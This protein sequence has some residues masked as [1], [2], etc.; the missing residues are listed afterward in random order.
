MA[1]RF[2]VRPEGLFDLASGAAVELDVLPPARPAAHRAW[3]ERMTTLA[4]LWHPHLL[5]PLDFGLLPNGHRFAARPA[6]APASCGRGACAAVLASAARFLG[7]QGLTAG[8]ADARRVR[9]AD[10]HL[11]VVVDERTGLPLADG[12]ARG[13]GG[14]ASRRGRVAPRR[15]LPTAGVRLQPRVAFARIV[16]VLDTVTPG[17]P[18]SIRV[19][20]AKGSGLSTLLAIVAAEARRRGLV[21]VDA[22]VAGRWP[23]LLP[24]LDGRHVLVID[25]AGQ[26]RAAAGLLVRLGLSGT[27]GH[28]LLSC[29][30]PDAP[31]AGVVDLDPIPADRLA[32]MVTCD[33]PRPDGEVRAAAERSG[34]SPGRFLELLAA[35]AG[36]GRAAALVRESAPAYARVTCETDGDT[37]APRETQADATAPFIAR[38]P[39]RVAALSRRGRWAAVIRLWRASLAACERRNDERGAAEA[40]LAL[41]ELL[42]D[43][44]DWSGAEAL[45][46]RAARTG[47]AASKARAA[48]G[49]ARVLT[50]E[51]RLAEAEAA[52]RAAAVAAGIVGD[53]ELSERARLAL[54]RVLF[55]QGRFRE[56]ADEL[57]RRF[58]DGSALEP[59]RLRR[60]ARTRLALGDIGLAART[61]A[62][63]L[64]AARRSGTPRDLAASH[65]LMARIAAN[66]GDEAA[67]R[68]HVADALRGSARAGLIGSA[69]RVRLAL[70]EGAVA[71]RRVDEA[72]RLGKRLAAR[73]ARAAPLV[74]ARVNAVLAA[75]GDAGASAA[76]PRFVESSGAHGLSPQRTE[77]VDM[78]VVHEAGELMRVCQEADDARAALKGVCR[79]LAERL[80]A[81]TVAVVGRGHGTTATI[82]HAGAAWPVVETLASRV[83]DT[84]VALQPR[85]GSGDLEGAAPVRYAGRTIGA[86]ACRWDL[87]VR[88]DASRV[89]ALLATAATACAPAAQ[90]EIDAR[91]AP[92]PAASS[93]A[94]PAL[95]GDSQAIEAVR[96]MVLRASA[97][98][99]A[100]LVEGESGS[101]KELVARAIHE[102]G[103]RRGYRFCAVNCAALGEDLLEA[104]LF[105]H[106]KGAFTG[107]VAGRAGLFEEA[108]RGTLFL[109]EVS[110]L[111]PRGQAKLLRA[112]QENEVRRLGE[113]LPRRV[114]VRVVAASNRSLE[115][116]V[117]AGRF[118]SDLRYRLDVL[119]IAVPPLR[120]RPEDV[121]RLAAHF[122]QQA[123]ARTGSRAT[124][125]PE[126]V[127]ALARYDWPGNV[128]EL[129]NVLASLAVAC[130]PRGRV[131][132]GALPA[133]LA[134]VAARLGVRLD[135]ARLSFER[136]FV[137]A[138]LARAGG[139][140]GRAAH[141]L[142]VTRQG[143]AKLIK[144]LDI[145]PGDLAAGA[146]LL[147]MLAAWLG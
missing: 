69:L 82:S 95:V 26:G 54:A 92:P 130:G 79:T 10:G 111:S 52:A 138:A 21:P 37:E 145:D 100:V 134:G 45:F 113:N 19:R 85:V 56:T 144:R 102:L 126:A 47:T 41:A 14:A 48:A 64:E 110:E 78:D 38:P 112:I 107:A 139:H 63:A 6:T 105:G 12:S 4:G 16:E 89:M 1:D 24:W 73:T 50:D 30:G 147:A 61:A 20:A 70:A 86:L 29:V 93:R 120:D 123:T 34:G 142:G 71:G 72:R 36:R 116:E 137:R 128:R 127:A 74:R 44:G 67:T 84:G 31:D 124:L 77:D 80:Q 75:A 136:R 119:R 27:R 49:L 108:D 46:R 9:D 51:G 40:A 55:W 59:A 53:R 43:R 101:G 104:E 5:V 66:L 94:V 23:G 97:A 98:P 87:D 135:E 90:A 129:Q 25:R 132:P 35:G 115:A 114:D 22:R 8:R 133:R 11:R 76:L 118:R 39:A 91:L 57:A 15:R 131:G 60:V 109:D 18:R 146:G 141:A 17:A 42:L 32:R 106:A 28:V 140:R 121:P 88:C 58:A 99:F 65:A 3:L 96:Q 143:L 125:A 68:A 83:L 13:V 33:P 81:R 122:W 117:A 103:P 2:V 7:A 62:A